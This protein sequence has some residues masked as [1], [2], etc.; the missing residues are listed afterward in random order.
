MTSNVL[1]EARCQYSTTQT[2]KML[3]IMKNAASAFCKWIKT[4]QHSTPN[5]ASVDILYFILSVNTLSTRWLTNTN[6]SF[7]SNT[8]V[9]RCGN[10]QFVQYVDKESKEGSDCSKLGS[11]T[12]DAGIAPKRLAQAL[13]W[14]CSIGKCIICTFVLLFASQMFLFHV[15]V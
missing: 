9:N 5:L 6:L 4:Y 15:Y 10:K 12:L 14:A 13:N 2:L 3:C 8:A 11:L 1:T 7:L